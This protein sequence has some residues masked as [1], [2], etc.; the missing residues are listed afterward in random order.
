MNKLSIALLSVSVVIASPAW[1]QFFPPVN[2]APKSIIV[3]QNGPGFL[4]GY[5]GE[6]E[7]RGGLRRGLDGWWYP[8]S[9]FAAGSIVGGA[10][11]AQDDGPP[12]PPPGYEPPPPGY[13]PPGHRM[14]QDLPPEHFA[15]CAKR[16]RSYVASDNSYVPR[17]GIRAHCMSPYS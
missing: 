7:P 10:I 17:P 13:R 11:A 1:A 5:R 16:Y 4:N 2:E 3:A 15:W 6:P 9:A 8:L 14:R 12:P